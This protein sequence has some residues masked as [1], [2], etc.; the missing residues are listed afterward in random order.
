VLSRGAARGLGFAKLVSLGNEADLGA[1][2]MVELLADDPETR[3][4]L[5]FLETVRD[6]PRLAVAARAAHAAGRP[7]VA[8]KLGRSALGQALARSHTGALAGSDAAMDAFFRDC[9]IVRVDMLETLVEIA[10]LLAGRTPPQL[11]RAPRVAVVTTSGGGAASVVDRL[12]LHG[13]ETVAPGSDAPIIDLTMAATPQ[14]YAAALDA[15]IESPECDGVLAVVG[16]SAQFHP[17]LAVEPILAAKRTAKPLAAFFTPHAER[18]LRLLGKAGIAAFRTP[19]A[20]ADA[21]AAYFAWRAPRRAPPLPPVELPRAAVE[22][23]ASLG[24]ALAQSQVAQAPEFEHTVPYP[25]AAKIHSSG[26]AHKTEVGGVILGIRDRD[27]FVAKARSLRSAQVLVQRMETGLAE[28][29][30]GYRDDPLVGPVVLVGAGGVL[31]EV[32]QDFVLRLAPVSVA[33]AGEMI[34]EVKGLAVIRGFRGLPKGDVRALAQAVSAMSRLALVP[35]R[36]VAEAECNPVIVK[37]SGA[38]AVDSLIV[39]KE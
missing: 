24:I 29:I 11:A 33:E 10:P 4:I 2:E 36:P 23:F 38:V 35:G 3:V 39:M 14:K 28:A 32:Y 7:V 37:P 26:V 8:Y 17:Q 13:I 27:E 16:S 21:F 5:L 1:G 31:A 9:G 19:E 34:G 6:A 15:L 25:V 18:S 22:V 12:G 20:C 30:V